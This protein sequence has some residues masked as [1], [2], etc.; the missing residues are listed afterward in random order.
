MEDLGTNLSNPKVLMPDKAAERKHYELRGRYED[1][2][3]KF[4]TDMA[5]YES[6]PVNLDLKTKFTGFEGVFC[7]YRNLNKIPIEKDTDEDWAEED[8][9]I[10]VFVGKG[11]YVEGYEE[12]VQYV[13][14]IFQTLPQDI[15][16]HILQLMEEIPIYDFSI[17]NE[18]FDVI[19]D[20][21][22]VNM[23]DPVEKYMSVLN[24]MLEL[25]KILSNAEIS[26]EA[27]NKEIITEYKR[28][29][30]SYCSSKFLMGMKPNCPNCGGNYEG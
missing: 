13:L 29:Q 18:E 19:A 8:Q 16:D 4:Y 24:I 26:A 5:D 17:G 30:C 14:S 9:S 23:E 3:V 1:I 12:G 28:V 20:D 6:Y 21:S 27:V 11:I 10:R 15:L 2:P 7:L 22:P 25:K